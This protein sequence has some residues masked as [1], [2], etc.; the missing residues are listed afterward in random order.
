[1]RSGFVRNLEIDYEDEAG[2][3]IPVEI[4]ATLI[5]SGG[6]TQVIALCRDI[7]ERKKDHSALMESE[8]NI[9]FLLNTPG[10]RLYR[11]GQP[12]GLL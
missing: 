4:N 5:R 2:N 9:T 11:P 1:M 3:I 10:R 12:A 6:S 8:E 7:S